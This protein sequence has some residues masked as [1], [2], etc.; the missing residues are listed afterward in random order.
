MSEFP[1]FTPYVLKNYGTPCDQT[2]EGT[3]E[4]QAL[5]YIAHDDLESAHNLV[6]EKS[7]DLAAYIHGIIHRREGDFFNANYWFQHSEPLPGLIGVR[8]DVLTKYAKEDP[9]KHA[10]EFRQE[11]SKLVEIAASY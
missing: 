8:P 9:D 10:D 3:P 2:F 6:Q 4:Q 11:W 1:S 7:G 5:Q